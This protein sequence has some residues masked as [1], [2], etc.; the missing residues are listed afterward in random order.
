MH[1][2]Q[3]S[4]IRRKLDYYF[5]DAPDWVRVVWPRPESFSWFVKHY[6]D[7]LRSHGALLRLGR[8]YFIDIDQFPPA[9]EK[10][11][12]LCEEVSA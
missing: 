12:G 11:L 8:D 9:A 3:L 4:R 2:G 7:E 6:R 10:I 1:H 5:H